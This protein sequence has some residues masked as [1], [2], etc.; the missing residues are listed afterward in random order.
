MTRVRISP[1]AGAPFEATVDTDVALANLQMEALHHHGP[2]VRVEVLDAP[3]PVVGP[4]AIILGSRELTATEAARWWAWVEVSGWLASAERPALV[5]TTDA[6]GAARVAREVSLGA[7]LAYES[8]G[9]HGTVRLGPRCVR[10]WH[11]GPTA[12]SPSRA[13]ERAAAMLADA[14]A[15][16]GDVVRVL[17]LHA[18]WDFRGGGADRWAADRA[19]AAGFEVTELT[20]PPEHGPERAAASARTA[21]TTTASTEGTTAP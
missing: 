5:L 18:A 15:R 19:R 12:E 10:R 11:D 16:A 4:V 17:V 13:V 3:P 20:C 9:Y 2:G 1:P 7:A 21:D 14:F 8:W 6:R